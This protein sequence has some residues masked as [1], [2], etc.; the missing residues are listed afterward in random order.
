MVSLHNVMKA[1]RMLADW[2]KRSTLLG[3]Q[4]TMSQGSHVRPRVYHAVVEV[5]CDV[6]NGSQEL[7][8][9]EGATS[10]ARRGGWRV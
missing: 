5:E 6:S 10:T 3:C 9:E 2:K 8:E 7:F 1:T 4:T